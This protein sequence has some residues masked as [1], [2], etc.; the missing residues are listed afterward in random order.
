MPAFGVLVGCGGGETS[1]TS[2]E[3][4]GAQFRSVLGQLCA[5]RHFT[6]LVLASA[7]SCVKWKQLH[8]THR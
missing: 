1:G 3:K 4:E 7:S 6:V 5:L 8:Q 2:A